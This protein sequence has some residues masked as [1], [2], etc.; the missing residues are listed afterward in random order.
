MPMIARVHAGHAPADQPAERAKPALAREV[1]AGHDQRGGAVAD[2]RRVARGH[3]A[4]LPEVGRKL[5]QAL[6]R[7]VRAHVLVGRPGHL[8]PGLPVLERDRH[9][10]VRERAR[11]PARPWRTP[12]SAPRKQS[13]ASRPM[14]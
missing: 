5:G 3:H 8:L 13:T 2:P 14:P 1:L 11:V 12:G 10:L 4:V 6:G 7:G 9:H